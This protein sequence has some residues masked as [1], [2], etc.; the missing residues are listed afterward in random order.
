MLFRSTAV[1]PTASPAAAADPAMAELASE[2]R[3]RLDRVLVA[4]GAP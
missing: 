2:V 4:L 1:D 3:Q